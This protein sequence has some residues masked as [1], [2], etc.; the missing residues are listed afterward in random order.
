MNA[1]G[2]P[3]LRLFI[4]LSRLSHLLSNAVPLIP[5]YNFSLSGQKTYLKIRVKRNET[6]ASRRQTSPL[7][8]VHR[9]AERHNRFQR[10]AITPTTERFGNRPLK[11]SYSGAVLTENPRPARVTLK[12]LILFLSQNRQDPRL[13]YTSSPA[14]FY[15]N[16]RDNNQTPN[17]RDAGIG[18]PTQREGQ[19]FSDRKRQSK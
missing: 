7:Q 8:E 5:V 15:N 19:L 12:I 11:P 13:Q 9:P 18:V 6:Q 17:R 14:S 1:E 3:F 10:A 2:L 16:A 4:Y